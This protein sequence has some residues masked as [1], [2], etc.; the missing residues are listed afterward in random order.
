MTQVLFLGHS[1][2]Y[3]VIAYL[4]PTVLTQGHLVP[5]GLETDVNRNI[6][7]LL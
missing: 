2:Y 1:S 4:D 5:W 7:N 6:S 3:A